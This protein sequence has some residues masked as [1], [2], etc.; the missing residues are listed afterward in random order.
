MNLSIHNRDPYG[1]WPVR[2]S[3]VII[4]TILPV[5]TVKVLLMGLSSIALRGLRVH[6]KADKPT[7]T[8]ND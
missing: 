4:H 5:L 3:S 2:L 6:N 8:A 1:S 7:V